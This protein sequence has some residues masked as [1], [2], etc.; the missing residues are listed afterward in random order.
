MR[1]V[2]E[3]KKKYAE[4]TD[5][6]KLENI[7]AD[8]MQ[9]FRYTTSS[10]MTVIGKAPDRVIALTIYSDNAFEHEF[11]QNPEDDSRGD[12]CLRVEV[13]P[14]PPPPSCTRRK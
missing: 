6:E 7:I 9:S 5:V 13:P 12:I 2:K 3:E 4:I 11:N 8:M 14:P 10:I 1:H